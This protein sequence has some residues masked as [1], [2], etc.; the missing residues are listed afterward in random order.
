MFSLVVKNPL[1]LCLFYIPSKKR[2]HTLRVCD[3]FFEGK[4]FF[5]IMSALYNLTEKFDILSIK[6]YLQ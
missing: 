2:L 6:V 1:E 4:K 3:V 5:R